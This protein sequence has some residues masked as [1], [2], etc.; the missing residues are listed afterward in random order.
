MDQFLNARL[1]SLELKVGVEVQ[2]QENDGFFTKEAVNKAVST[3]MEEGN[4]IGK[5]VRSNH[6]KW[7]QFLLWEGLEESYMSSFIQS[8]QELL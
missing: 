5:E 4:E 1:M 7:R 3:V 6:A 8:L 2:K